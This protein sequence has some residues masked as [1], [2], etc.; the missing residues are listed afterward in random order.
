MTEWPFET[1]ETSTMDEIRTTLRKG[2]KV[3]LL[4]MLAL[5]LVA[6]IYGGWKYWFQLPEK[7]A[8]YV[9]YMAAVESYADLIARADAAKAAGGTLNPEEIAEYEASEKVLTQY[10]GDKPQRPSKYDGIITLWVWLI[11]G[12]SGVPFLIWPLWKHRGGGWIL[13]ADGS[14]RTP[15]GEEIPAE[16][17]VDIDM[18]SWRGLINPQASNKSTWQARLILKDGRK[19]VIDDYPWDGASRIIGRLAHR[20]HPDTWDENGEPIPAGITAAAESLS[21]KSAPEE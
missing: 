15:K 9:E 18:T 16:A 19:V 20:F 13:H 12:L 21:Q 17:I 4:V 3:K 14:A 5:C 6:G 10:A 7:E 1:P 8:V 11:G 2:Q